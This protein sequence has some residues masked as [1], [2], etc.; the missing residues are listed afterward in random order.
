VGDLKETIQ[1]QKDEWEKQQRELGE[2]YG[3]SIESAE[4][5]GLVLPKDL[6]E[7]S[8]KLKGENASQ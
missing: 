2:I 3:D 1:K 8:L 6:L 5:D 4:E 7:E